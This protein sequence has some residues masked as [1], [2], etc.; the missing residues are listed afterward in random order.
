MGYRVEALNI[1]KKLDAISLNKME[2][3]SEYL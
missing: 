2:D 1:A 3:L